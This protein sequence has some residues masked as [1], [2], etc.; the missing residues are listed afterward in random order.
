[1]GDHLGAARLLIRVCN[2]ISQFHHNKVPIITTTVG[3]C[4][5]GGLKAA[6]Y[7]WACVLIRPENI[8]NIPP[9]FK[10]KIEQI[11]RKPVR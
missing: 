5:Q 9:K 8:N 6:A 1:M 7:Q 3:E 11:A 4:A 2:N 10:T